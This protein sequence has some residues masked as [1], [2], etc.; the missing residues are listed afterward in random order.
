MMSI[1]GLK[2]IGGKTIPGGILQSGGCNYGNGI[3]RAINRYADFSGS[4]LRLL[5]DRSYA[6]LLALILSS[7]K[8]L[9]EG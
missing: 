7:L 8:F 6:H 2:I 9:L 1:Q 4:A 3:K 5:H